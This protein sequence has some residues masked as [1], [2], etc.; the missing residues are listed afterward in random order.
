M[1]LQELRK[2]LMEKRDELL[3]RADEINRVLDLFPKV[4]SLIKESITKEAER[5]APEYKLTPSPPPHEKR[6]VFYADIPLKEA[7]A[8]VMSDGNWHSSAEIEKGM[9]QLCGRVVNSD[10][11]SKTRYNFAKRS[12]NG[13]K[14]IT[15]EIE[16]VKFWKTQSDADPKPKFSGEVE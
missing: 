6:K 16:G 12:P 2:V 7:Y 10:A 3:T 9:T 14:V 15:K 4:E 5:A 13:M 8:K 1:N 11:V